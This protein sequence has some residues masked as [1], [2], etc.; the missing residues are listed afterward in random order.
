MVFLSNYS[1][2]LIFL[3]CQRYVCGYVC[4]N[5]YKQSPFIRKSLQKSIS[6][7]H[8]LVEELVHHTID[9]DNASN[10]AI[11]INRHIASFR[12]SNTLP[13]TVIFSTI[14]SFTMNTYASSEEALQLLHG[15]TP[16]VP[17][18]VTWVVLIVG[19][20]L[21]QYKIYKFIGSI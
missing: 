8:Q 9:L 3:F 7:K 6:N 19:L 16:L 1:K 17:E 10:S 13:F 5:Q 14:F 18:S 4:M 2:I 11:E 12:F 21:I 15:Y 20:Y